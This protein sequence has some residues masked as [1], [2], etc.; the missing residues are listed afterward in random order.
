LRPEGAGGVDPVVVFGE[1][2][3]GAGIVGG[4]RVEDGGGGAQG[5]GLA[6]G[7]ADVRVVGLEGEV[8]EVLTGLWRREV[9][10]AA[11]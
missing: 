7:S 3:G 10:R 8:W 11:A 6:D 1:G 4:G 9:W 2:R 5:R